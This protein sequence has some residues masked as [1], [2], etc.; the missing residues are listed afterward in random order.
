M[1]KPDRALLIVSI[2]TFALLSVIALWRIILFNFTDQ[3]ERELL[4][5]AIYLLVYLI[6]FAGFSLGT[7]DR[8]AD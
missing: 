6:W 8:K 2:L 4:R 3:S 1:N 5:T 7:R